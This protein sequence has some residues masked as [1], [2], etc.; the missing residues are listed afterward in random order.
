MSATPF[1]VG[2][3]EEYQLVDRD[4]GALRSRAS[5]VLDANGIVKEIIQSS[6]LGEARDHAAQ[7]KAL[8]NA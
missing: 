8:A 6:G 3:E 5:Y 1:S 4:T 7:V 2:V